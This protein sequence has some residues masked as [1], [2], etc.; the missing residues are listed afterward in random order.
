MNAFQRASTLCTCFLVL[1]IAAGP[2]AAD[3]DRQANV[4]RAAQFATVREALSDS[5]TIPVIVELSVPGLERL[6]LTSRRAKTADAAEEADVKVSRAIETIASQETAKLAPF[7]HRVHR[8]YKTVPFV[9]AAVSREALAA[10]EASPDVVGVSLDTLSRP[11]LNNTVNIIGAT[12]SWSLGFDGTGWFV[13]VLDTGI[14][15]SHE[16]FGGSVRFVTPLMGPTPS[17]I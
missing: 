6:Q 3:P 7:T 11:S 12:D 9:A 14:R 15:A 4:H 1:V 17:R 16:F 8:T 13:A 2:A 10:L 5:E